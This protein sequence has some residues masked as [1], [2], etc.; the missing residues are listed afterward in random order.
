MAVSPSRAI[1]RNPESVEGKWKN[2]QRVTCRPPLAVLDMSRSELDA[3]MF[4]DVVT[5]EERQ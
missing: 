2:S 1:S 4:L 3:S 5:R